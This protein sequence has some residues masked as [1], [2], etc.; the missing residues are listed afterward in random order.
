MGTIVAMSGGDTRIMEEYMMDLC[1][2]SAPKLLLIPTASHDSWGFM[3]GMNKEF[4]SK[5]G[6]MVDFL[7]LLNQNLTSEYIRDKILAADIIYVG[8]GSAAF[9]TDVWNYYKLS[10]I[11]KEAFD[12][13]AILSGTSAG[14]ICWFKYGHGDSNFEVN[15][16]GKWGYRKNYGTGL[17]QAL[18]CPHFAPG[19][20]H[21]EHV[22]KF[23]TVP[24]I[25]VEDNCALIV[26][27]NKYKIMKSHMQSKVFKY[28]NDNGNV[29]SKELDN[30]EFED[31]AN[32][33]E[34]KL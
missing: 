18:N 14:S 4:N 33:V 9:M 20:L 3:Q 13:G 19:Y 30:E 24:A 11:M 6:C 22:M 2:K 21:F 23:Y 15:D 26:Q 25:A 27:D 5:Y 28:I 10:P 16:K 31:I 34:N 32:L 17:I 29:I 7:L 8:G 1:G 12:K